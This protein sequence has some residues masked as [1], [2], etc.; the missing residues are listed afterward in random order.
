MREAIE[1]VIKGLEKHSAYHGKKYT[2]KWEDDR[3]YH[4][5]VETGLDMA[6]KHLKEVLTHEKP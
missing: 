3:Q 2:N 6:I 1:Q 4:L 5:G